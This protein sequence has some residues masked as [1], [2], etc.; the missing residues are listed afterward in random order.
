M[1]T[2]LPPIFSAE[3]PGEIDKK[4]YFHIS[5]RG[6]PSELYASIKSSVDLFITELPFIGDLHEQLSLLFLL[7]MLAIWH[8]FHVYKQ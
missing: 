1:D 6:Q 2:G 7:L 4:K 3:P 8:F 5:D